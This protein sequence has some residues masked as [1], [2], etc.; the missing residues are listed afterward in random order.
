MTAFAGQLEVLPG[1]Y[2]R[3]AVE[4]IARTLPALASPQSRTVPR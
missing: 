3:R 1:E 2:R 4:L